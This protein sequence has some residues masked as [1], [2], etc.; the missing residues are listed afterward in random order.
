MSQLL[1]KPEQTKL[2]PGRSPI[3]QIAERSPLQ[4]SQNINQSKIR[5]EVLIPESSIIKKGSG[6]HDKVIQ[7]SNYTI[8]QTMSECDAISITIRRKGIQDIRREIP[9]YADRI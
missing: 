1:D 9:A 4:Q 2:L 3:I 8:P 7:V 6:H 5:L